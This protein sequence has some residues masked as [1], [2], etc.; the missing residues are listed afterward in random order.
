MRLMVRSV[1]PVVVCCIGT[2]PVVGAR[3]AATNGAAPA[4]GAAQGAVA[5]ALVIAGTVAWLRYREPMK[6]WWR[7]MLKESQEES[8]RRA[9]GR[10]A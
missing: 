5:A 2:L 7:T 1:L 4:S 8:K 9:A 3:V 6:A 10:A